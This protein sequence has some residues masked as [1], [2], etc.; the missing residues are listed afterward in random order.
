[1]EN[2]SKT[3]QNRAKPNAL[4]HL[5]LNG[6]WEEKMSNT[7]QEEVTA[8]IQP[9]DTADD[10][11]DRWLSHNRDTLHTTATF[12]QLLPHLLGTGVTSAIGRDRLWTLKHRCYH[13]H[14]LQTMCLEWHEFRVH[15][16]PHFP[17]DGN[18]TNVTRTI[19]LCTS[20][21]HAPSK[22]KRTATIQN[23]MSTPL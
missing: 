22:A 10:L 4:G 3:E 19:K 23:E 1:M 2:S 14:I 6:P 8:N 7:H 9:T 12:G 20:T 13:S 15:P 18:A 5:R 17:L 16:P 21:P 11:G